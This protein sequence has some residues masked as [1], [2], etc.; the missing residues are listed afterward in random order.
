M[1][2]KKQVL[3]HESNMK[4]VPYVVI[5]Y[6]PS[7][8][9]IGEIINK[10]WGLLALSQ[11]SSVKYRMSLNV[12]RYWHLKCKTTFLTFWPIQNWISADLLQDLYLH[13]KDT[14]VPIVSVSMNKQN[15]FVRIKM[16]LFCLKVILI[17]LQKM[18]WN[19]MHNMLDRHAKRYW[20]VMGLTF[21]I[22]KIISQM[23]LCI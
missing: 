17:A 7:L 13:V 19:V 23:F 5:T 2:F 6:N 9:R 20:T 10:Y 11:K 4:M 12:S 1:H 16:R 18:L 14:D 3:F 15:A 8:S 21:V 22:I